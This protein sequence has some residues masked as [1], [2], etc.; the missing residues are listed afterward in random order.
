MPRALFVLPS[1][2]RRGAELE[3]LGLAHKLAGSGAIAASVVALR[4]A[5]AGTPPLEVE[6]LGSSAR[7]PSSLRHLRRRAR[8]ADVVVAF[9]STALPACAIALTTQSAPPFIYRSIGDPT[10]WVRGRSHRFRTALLMRRSAHVVALWEG[11]RASLVRLY[12]LDQRHTSVIP[13]ARSI[14]LFDVPSPLQRAAARKSLDVPDRARMVLYLGALTKEKRV[15]RVIEAVASLRDAMLLVAGDGPERRRLEDQA[16]STA[17]GDRVRFAGLVADPAGVLAAADALVLTSRTEGMPGAVIEALLCGVPVVA[18][19]TGAIPEMILDGVTGR[20]TGDG[21]V[22]RT[23]QALREVT[24]PSFHSGST[25]RVSAAQR[26][27]LDTVAAQWARL[28]ED[29]ARRHR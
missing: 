19:S 6:V 18:P 22:R 12:G 7:G 28:L 29:V 1:A 4:G 3:G 11:A 27:D 17:G 25:L 15:D 14:A 23:E 26:F 9:G 20:L 16:A 2:T 13:N 21:S 5:R 10:E 24:G 8:A